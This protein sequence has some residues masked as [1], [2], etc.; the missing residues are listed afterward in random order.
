MFPTVHEMKE[1][2]MTQNHFL[3]EPWWEKV[4]QPTGWP[5]II[6]IHNKY[7]LQVSLGWDSIYLFVHQKFRRE[8]ARGR[9]YKTVFVPHLSQDLFLLSPPPFLGQ[10]AK[11]F[12]FFTIERAR[13]WVNYKI[14]SI[15]TCLDFSGQV[16]I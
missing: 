16:I 5:G 8:V 12:F 4:G 7:T 11:F 10:S 15:S 2:S 14:F 1:Q 6:D 3:I 9:L 13:I